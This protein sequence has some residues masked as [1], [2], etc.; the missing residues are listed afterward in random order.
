MQ[1]ITII[2]LAENVGEYSL[3]GLTSWRHSQ[4]QPYARHTSRLK[5]RAEQYC[6]KIGWGWP[7]LGLQ[8]VTGGVTDI[9]C[10]L[11]ALAVEQFADFLVELV[12]FRSQWAAGRIASER[13]DFLNQAVIPAIPALRFFLGKD[14]CFDLAF[15]KSLAQ[16]TSLDLPS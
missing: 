15:R 11:A 8:L 10:P 2:G 13:L 14:A 3:F 5:S 12:V 4:Q 16:N 1:V 7:R 9:E 6:T